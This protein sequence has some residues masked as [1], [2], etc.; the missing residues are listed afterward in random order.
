MKLSMSRRGFLNTLIIAPFIKI[1]SVHKT[2]IN[3]ITRVS[4]RNMR[5]PLELRPDAKWSYAPSQKQ[6]YD[7]LAKLVNILETDKRQRQ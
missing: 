5:I 4:V 7:E 2:A 6:A 1:K 3:K